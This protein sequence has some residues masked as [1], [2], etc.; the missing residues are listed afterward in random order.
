MLLCILMYN[1]IF[2]MYGKNRNRDPVKTKYD[3]PVQVINFY[4]HSM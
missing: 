4:T 2:K 3:N 1:A